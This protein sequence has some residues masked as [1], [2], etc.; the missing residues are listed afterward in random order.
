MAKQDRKT[1]SAQRLDDGSFL[2][3]TTVYDSHLCVDHVV[4][5]G[6]TKSVKE[7]Q[8]KLKEELHDDVSID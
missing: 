5:V 2:M 3:Q 6:T 1:F 4:F 8:E 7:L